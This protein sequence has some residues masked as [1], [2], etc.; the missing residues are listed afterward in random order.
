MS[1]SV[2]ATEGAKLPADPVVVLEL[3]EA[4]TDSALEIEPE[5]S[6]VLSS[7]N[8]TNERWDNESSYRPRANA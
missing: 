3:C 7:L 8:F 4:G 1:V 5:F 2:T 6:G